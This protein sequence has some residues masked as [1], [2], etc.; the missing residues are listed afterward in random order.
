MEWRRQPVR[1]TKVENTGLESGDCI[2]SSY[3]LSLV[4]LSYLQPTH[5]FAFGEEFRLCCILG[6]LACKSVRHLNLLPYSQ[7]GCNSPLQLLANVPRKLTLYKEEADNPGNRMGE[8]T[9]LVERRGIKE[10]ILSWREWISKARNRTRLDN[11]QNFS[12]VS[13]LDVLVVECSRFSVSGAS[14]RQ[15]IFG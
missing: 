9:R 11:P 1:S 15:L 3:E 12:C 4:A 6:N 7:T 8:I 2:Y 13:N 10:R 5:E 14:N